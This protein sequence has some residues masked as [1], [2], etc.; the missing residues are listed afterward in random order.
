MPIL[1]NNAAAA[2]ICA[3]FLP[4]ARP[5]YV[6]GMLIGDDL[7]SLLSAMFL[8]QRFG[9]PVVGV[10]CQ[11]QRLWH[12]LAPDV[13]R[14]K[15]C[16]G[17]LVAVDLD[18]YH[19]NV[20]SI[21]HHIL[22]LEPDADLPGHSHSLNPNLL[23]GFS[24]AQGYRRKYPLATVHL[25]HWLLGEKTPGEGAALLCWLADSAFINA[26]RYRANVEE[27]A[28]GYLHTA[29]FGYRVPDFQTIDFEE[30]LQK[31]ILSV[32][33]RNPLCRAGRG[34]CRSRHLGLGGYQC[35]FADPNRENA[36]LQDLLERLSELSGWPV[37]PFPT[38]LPHCI[39]GQRREMAV[40]ALR[41]HA[42]PDFAAWLEAQEVFSYA[43][44]FA[45][46]LNYT[47]GMGF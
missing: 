45:D 25:L 30:L 27:W 35:Q 36:L 44:T 12:C 39:A 40:A 38:V 37:L 15:L 42:Q 32:L 14:E 1:S 47:N 21:G 31:N 22:T 2:D 5:D 13:F 34:P 26:Q 7:D 11:Y 41:R 28:G 8:H 3:A 9:W 20:P 24:V 19:P 4:F 23:R 6:E 29:D 46:R 16:S 33:L 18:I 43:F 17:R 10:Y